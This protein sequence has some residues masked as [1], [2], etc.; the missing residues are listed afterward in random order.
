MTQQT[1]VRNTLLEDIIL[2]GVVTQAPTYSKNLGLTIPF[3]AR[4]TRFSDHI[5]DKLTRYINYNQ[6]NV[7]FTVPLPI[8]KGDILGVYG[9]R[10]GIGEYR[11]EG[12]SPTRIE[13][14]DSKNDI[15]AIYYQIIS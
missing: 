4:S 9:Y 12:F 3:T 15:R 14:L 10:R 11:V 8:F 13:V 5:S 6:I 7:K 2:V 1:E